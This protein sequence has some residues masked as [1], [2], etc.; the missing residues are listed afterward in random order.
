MLFF[1]HAYVE[2]EQDGGREEKLFD[3]IV[4]HQQHIDRREERCL[5]RLNEFN[6]SFF[7]SKTGGILV[8]IDTNS[9]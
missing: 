9:E 8:D 7:E 5:E 2:I 3:T 6:Q 1:R 4:H